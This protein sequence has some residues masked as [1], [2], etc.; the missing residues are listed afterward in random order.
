MLD[1]Q[2]A[3]ADQ[4]LRRDRGWPADACAVEAELDTCQTFPS[5]EQSRD[6]TPASEVKRALEA[7]R[8]GLTEV[9]ERERAR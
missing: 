4:A 6:S 5:P 9:L 3:A 1:A 2:V 7:R 8:A